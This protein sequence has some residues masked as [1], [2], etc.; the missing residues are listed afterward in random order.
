MVNLRGLGTSD[1]HLSNIGASAQA[2]ETAAVEKKKK[3]IRDKLANL[4]PREARKMLEKEY[5]RN[6]DDP[7]EQEII[8]KLTEEIRKNADKFV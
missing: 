5:G 8:E 7:G 2:G 6:I 3:E 4:T 1:A